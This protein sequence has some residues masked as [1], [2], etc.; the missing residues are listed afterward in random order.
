[1]HYNRLW[2]NAL[3]ILEGADFVRFTR[4]LAILVVFGAASSAL[5][6]DFN[7]LSAPDPTMMQRYY[8]PRVAA[9]RPTMEAMVA[10]CAD[11][12]STEAVQSRLRAA[13]VERLGGLPE[14]TPLNAR[15]VGQGEKPGFRYE[16]VMFESQPGIFVT[17]VVYLPL[18][19]GPY[20]GVLMPC[21]HSSNG[22]AEDAYQYA[23]ISLARH[24][25]AA[26]IYDPIGQGERYQYLDAA[27]K[28]QFGPTDEHNLLAPAAILTGTNV[29]TLRIWDGMRALD[30]LSARPDIDATRLGCTGN[31][32]GGTMTSY[33][34]ALDDR[35]AVAAPSCYLTTFPRLLETIGPQDAEQDFYDQAPLLDHAAFV[36]LRAPKPTLMCAATQDFFDI[37]GTWLTFR[38]AK[39]V[40]TSLG[41]PERMSI[42]ETNAKH[43]FSKPLREA[44]VQWMCRWLL[45][46]DEPVQEEEAEV[47]SEAEVQCTPDGQVLLL[48]GARHIAAVLRVRADARDQD[49]APLLERMAR[50]LTVDLKPA[51]QVQAHRAAV[52]AWEGAPVELV[53]L[54]SEPGITLPLLVIHP[55]EAPKG[56][57]V[58]LH[59]S[60]KQALL[61]PDGPVRKALDVGMLVVA[62]DLRGTGE[63]SAHT[64]HNAKLLG[65]DWQDFFRA[66]LMGD[67]L[68]R[69]RVQDILAV[70]RFVR[71]DLLSEGPVTLEAW[72]AAT[73]PA[74]HAVALQ[75][76][77][78]SAVTLHGGLRSWR[79][80]FDGPPPAGTLGNI[81][82]AGL[83]SYD[84]PELVDA[85][86]SQTQLRWE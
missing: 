11:A 51:I 28:P 57:T 40:Y 37:T 7:V 21:G 33:L 70:L 79:D 12:A 18:S 45:S 35:I 72:D 73:T 46:R 61:T 44:M 69:G 8:A 5:A 82:Q 53:E 13:F 2:T 39:R 10:E 29:A 6:G 24:G 50:V 66:Y 19:P 42:A 15:V 77:A 84:L 60:G 9:W 67:S 80:V 55:A 59:G 78:F 38:D 30:Y 62:A 85:A 22:K 56:V 43:G 52:Q 47:L 65:E 58:L 64:P 81:V 27:G 17:A 54:V 48:P 36:L 86:S 49:A 3:D 31:S 25:I 76:A 71:T 63:T 34:M 75:P 83:L 14:R 23:A 20:P 41:F 26:M 32:G 16:K 4:Y 1:M 68:L 74:L